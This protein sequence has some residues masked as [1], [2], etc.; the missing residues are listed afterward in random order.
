MGIAERKEREFKRREGEILDAAARLFE[1]EDWQLVTIERISQEAEIGKGTVYLHFP[2]K[3]AIYG[4]LALEFAGGVLTELQGIDAEQPPVERLRDAIRIFF[5]A[6]LH[7]RTH[8][9]V[10]EYCSLD[11]VRRRLGEATRSELERVEAEIIGIIHGILADGIRE[12]VFADRP[13][14]LLMI[15]AHATLAGAVRL[16]GSPCAPQANGGATEAQL[17]GEITR[18]ILAGLMYF[19]R[20][21]LAGGSAERALSPAEER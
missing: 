14:D 3:E 21:P 8:H 4:R 20:V 18:F 9:R 10:A 16:L 12:G 15:S 5:A 17:V 7:G 1:R 6:H 19:D 13:L 11:D 2:S